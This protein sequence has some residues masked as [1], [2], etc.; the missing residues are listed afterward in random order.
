MHNY[1]ITVNVITSYTNKHN[2][3]LMYNEKIELRAS[4]DGRSINVDAY[5]RPTDYIIH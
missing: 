1:Q 3:R 5:E 2:I 4:L